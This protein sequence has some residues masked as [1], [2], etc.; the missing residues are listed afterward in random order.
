MVEPD[1]PHPARLVTLGFIPEEPVLV[2]QVVRRAALVGL[3][4]GE[5]LADLPVVLTVPGHLPETVSPVE[6]MSTGIDHEH[7]K[8]QVRPSV[9]TCQL[10]GSKPRS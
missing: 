4:V 1:V 6:G 3:A 10:P 7:V 5:A 9:M 8:Y 2:D